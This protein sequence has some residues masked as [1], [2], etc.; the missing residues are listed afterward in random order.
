M[1]LHPGEVLQVV[2]A[3][4]ADVG[5]VFEVIGG[6]ALQP[7]AVINGCGF[8]GIFAHFLTHFVQA[9]TAVVEFH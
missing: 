6:E 5:Q 2:D 1:L 3:F 7:A 8:L 4:L 9:Q